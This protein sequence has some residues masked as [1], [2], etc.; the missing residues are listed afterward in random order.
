MHRPGQFIEQGLSHT[1]GLKSCRLEARSGDFSTLTVSFP[2]WRGW[3]GRSRVLRTEGAHSAVL[4]LEDREEYGVSQRKRHG[5]ESLRV[6]VSPCHL[7]ATLNLTEHSVRH[8]SKIYRGFHVKAIGKVEI[9][10]RVTLSQG[11][12]EAGK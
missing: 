2:G 6:E 3:I 1:W 12:A 10:P 5:L 9:C 4:S 11:G 8:T 7:L